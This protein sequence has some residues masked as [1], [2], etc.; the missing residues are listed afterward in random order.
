MFMMEKD[1]KKVNIPQET[2]IVQSFAFRLEQEGEAPAWAGRKSGSWVCSHWAHFCPSE[3]E[4]YAVLET[5]SEARR[6]SD[7]AAL[8]RSCVLG[9][10][11]RT[12]KRAGGSTDRW[13]PPAFLVLLVRGRAWES[14][15]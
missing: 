2:C 14:A 11:I 5:S 3:A 7:E 15:F 8:D 9:A 1:R 13:A 12:S 10:P 6:G 4:V